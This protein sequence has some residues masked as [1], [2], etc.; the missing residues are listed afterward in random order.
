MHQQ[1]INKTSDK[2]ILTGTHTDL[3]TIMS[4]IR[5]CAVVAGPS[6]CSHKRQKH[7]SENA[8]F[9]SI[10]IN[11]YSSFLKR[12]K[13]LYIFLISLVKMVEL[14]CNLNSWGKVHFQ[15][16]LKAHS[17]ITKN[18]RPVSGYKIISQALNISQSTVH[19]SNAEKVKH[20]PTKTWQ[21]T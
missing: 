8:F 12:F 15:F 19:H 21:W 17:S 18:L 16:F 3:N 11:K 7:P 5:K 13:K 10:F 2:C 1:F 6:F 14:S 20:K 4:T 9:W